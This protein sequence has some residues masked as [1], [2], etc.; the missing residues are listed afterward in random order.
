MCYTLAWYLFIHLEEGGEKGGKKAPL[1]MEG[2]L[3]D[4]LY[5][6]LVSF[7]FKSHSNHKKQSNQKEFQ[8]TTDVS[9]TM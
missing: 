4:Q 5:P 1:M 9:V 3:I 8:H 2:I 7:F 6:Y